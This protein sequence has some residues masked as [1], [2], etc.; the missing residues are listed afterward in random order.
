MRIATIS[1]IHIGDARRSKEFEEQKLEI[2]SS[3]LNLIQPDLVLN[4]ADTVSLN[5][6][7]RESAAPEECWQRYLD[8]RGSIKSRVI[9]VCLTREVPFFAEIFDTQNH[10]YSLVED[11]I[12]FVSLSPEHDN[13][14]TLSRKQLVWLENEIKSNKGKIMFFLSHVPVEQSTDRLPGKEI[15]LTDSKIIKEW[16]ADFARFSIFI[17][18]HFHK[19]PPPKLEKNHIMMMAGFID[20]LKEPENNMHIRQINLEDDFIEIN[21]I[22]VEVPS[23]SKKVKSEFKLSI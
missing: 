17:G 21:T 12:L 7:L 22:T 20:T 2:L 16:A 18:A 6:Y 1:D 3:E 19:I 5:K 10:Y 11:E 13:D 23:G 4:V 15:Y 9:E 14:H 8:F